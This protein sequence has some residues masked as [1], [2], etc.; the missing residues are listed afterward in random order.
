MWNFQIHVTYMYMYNNARPCYY[1][2]HILSQSMSDGI[3]VNVINIF[4]SPL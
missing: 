3:T 2:D 4:N 1:T